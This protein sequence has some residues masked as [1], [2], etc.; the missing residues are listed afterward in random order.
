VEFYRE[1]DSAKEKI[2]A[3][4][5]AYEGV[6]N[7]MLETLQNKNSLKARNLAFLA[8][9]GNIINKM[10][11]LQVRQV[12]ERAGV[13]NAHELSKKCILPY[14]V[15]KFLWDGVSQMI[16][17]KTINKLCRGLSVHPSQFFEYIP[18]PI[19]EPVKKPTKKTK[20]K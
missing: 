4:I 9:S 7:G 14:E 17:L 20:T 19:E 2:L 18:D 13:K 1:T 15:A 10:V 16:A 8:E 5:S 6:T 3:I 12:A 11:K